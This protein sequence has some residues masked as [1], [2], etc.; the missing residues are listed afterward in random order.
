MASLSVRVS[1]P[2]VLWTCSEPLAVP[3]TWSVGAVSAIASAV[4]DPS[5][6]A[7]AEAVRVRA[8]PPM[9]R[10]KR[11]DRRGLCRVVDRISP[12]DFH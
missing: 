5:V 3:L 7:P 11:R 9:E 12:W 6:T 4:M 1:V 2:S 10:R 8:N